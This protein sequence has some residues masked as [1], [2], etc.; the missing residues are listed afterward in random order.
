MQDYSAVLQDIVG[1][2][3][4]VVLFC[5]GVGCLDCTLDEDTVAWQQP[6]GANLDH[7]PR[8]KL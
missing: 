8:H 7:I 2:A 3:A 5:L 4:V 1:K 6:I